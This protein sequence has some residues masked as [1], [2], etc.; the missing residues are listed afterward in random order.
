MH[1]IKQRAPRNRTIELTDAEW[2][3]LRR[4]LVRVRAPISA[5]D[6][7]GKTINDDLFSC[8]P[9][10]P[11]S[12]V[13]LMVVD[14]PYNLDK[15]FHGHDFRKMPFAAYADWV[16]SWLRPLATT[17]KPNASIYVCA[18]WRSSAAVYQV[19]QR[20]FRVR[21]RITWEREKGRGTQGNWKNCLEDIWYFSASDSCVFNVGAVKLR[22]R[23]VA[24][25]RDVNGSPKD[26]QA[27]E[28]GN[29]R[30]THPS[31]L[32]TDLTVPFWS[33]P[34]NTE[35]PTQKPEKLMA[36]LI[37]ASSNPGDLVFDPFAGSGTTL[38]AAKKLG[39]RYCGVEIEERY[40]CIA[41]KRLAMAE[42]DRAIQGYAD[43]IFWERNSV[44]LRSTRRNGERRPLER[45]ATAS[46][47][48]LFDR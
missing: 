22:R 14:P 44:P 13:D 5:V 3:E 32:W 16:D 46:G 28:D 33:M 42:V 6:I 31:N 2:H 34:E 25:Y 19:G 41:E 26:W 1:A 9:C 30:I 21:N 36:K 4:R 17:L 20:Y 45:A 11:A 37:L 38:V 29:F 27:T 39:R 48:D 15:R 12:F 8:L 18:D 47:I 24:P 23:V 35:H 7:I 43:G 40:A 10:L